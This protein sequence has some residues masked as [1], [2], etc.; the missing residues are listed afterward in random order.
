VN[1]SRSGRAESNSQIRGQRYRSPLQTGTPY[2]PSPWTA[3]SAR[4]LP[5]RLNERRKIRPPWCGLCLPMYVIIVRTG[6][7]AFACAE[8]QYLGSG[9]SGPPYVTIDPSPSFE[10][11]GKEDRRC[12]CAASDLAMQGTGTTISTRTL[13]QSRLTRARPRLKHRMTCSSFLGVSIFDRARAVLRKPAVARADRVVPPVSR[14][15][16]SA[17]HSFKPKRGGCE[18]GRQASSMISASRSVSRD[19]YPNALPMRRVSPTA[20]GRQNHGG[21]LAHPQMFTGKS[22][23][24]Q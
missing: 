6:K 9:M 11:S 3:G 23:R 5:I 2:W 16:S 15:A 22:T 8:G 17:L 7:A 1:F 14:R 13:D 21:H 19:D 4:V 10:H 20:D 12:P 24:R 18:R